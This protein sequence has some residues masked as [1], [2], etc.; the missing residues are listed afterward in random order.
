[1]LRWIRNK[2]IFIPER[3]LQSLWKT[4]INTLK[5]T[6]S[7]SRYT[8]GEEWGKEAEREKDRDRQRE[9]EREEESNK[10]SLTGRHIKEKLQDNKDKQK[11]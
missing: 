9:G 5:N 7:Q 6:E 4:S 10:F 11:I 1:M 3:C 2:V 8:E